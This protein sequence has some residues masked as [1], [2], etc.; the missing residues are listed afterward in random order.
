MV[1]FVR[2]TPPEFKEYYI[3]MQAAKRSQAPLPSQVNVI[4]MCCLFE[5]SI[6]S[7]S[8]LEYNFMSLYLWSNS[9]ILTPFFLCSF[10][11]AA[12]HLIL[13]LKV[14]DDRVILDKTVGDQVSIW[15]RNRGFT[16]EAVTGHVCSGHTCSYTQIGDVFLCEKTGCVHGK[17]SVFIMILLTW[18][19]SVNL[20]SHVSAVCDDTCREVVLDQYSGLLVCTVSGQCFD[21]WIAF[22]EESDTVSI[23]CLGTLDFLSCYSWSFA[24]W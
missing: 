16:D 5:S 4:F 2:N 18:H 1:E 3:Q 13:I 6:S 7:Y 17:N 12:K 14:S 22:E 20:L 15:K 24:W 23:N 10:C 9:F 21:R 8:L 19:P 11:V